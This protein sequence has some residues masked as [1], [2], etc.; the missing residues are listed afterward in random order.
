MMSRR[1]KAVG[2][3]G[4]TTLVLAGCAGGSG[5]DGAD[6]VVTIDFLA[7]EYSEAT[8]PYWQDLIERFEAEN[9]GIKIALQTISWSDINTKI[10]TLVSTGEEPDIINLDSYAAFAADELLLPA[11]EVLPEQSYDD[12]IPALLENATFDGTVYG[13]PFVASARAL[14][15]NPDILAEA[16]V[17]EAPTTWAQLKEAALAVT[18]KTD[19]IGYGMPVGAPEAFGEFSI[20]AWN[21]GG[22]WKDG[23]NWA[24]NQPA[25]VEALE[26]MAAMYNAGVTQES[27]WVSNR[28]DLFKM[29]GEGQI[30]IIEGAAFLPAVMEGQG[31]TIPYEVVPSPTNGKAAQATLAVQDYLMVFNSTE[32][33]EE[34]G[35]FLSFFYESENYQA[36]LKA[37]G[38][39]PVTQSAA[40]DMADDPIAGPFVALLENARFYPTT[41]PNW[42]SVNQEAVAKLGLAISGE[43][44]AQ[45]VLD[46]LQQYA[47]GLR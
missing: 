25:N 10:N 6:G 5:T 3:L 1:M 45:Q 15:Y 8:A 44:S 37:E 18:E 16:G 40:D 26:A 46:A 14:F 29:F 23:E 20:W 9:E 42:P 30:G 19:S 43:Q 7:P 11:D 34:A 22:G 17:A 31:S 36:F 12:L 47:E 28:D 27:P 39:L 32:H 13:I 35:A 33:P 38:M 4:A 24:I 41:D 21:N 2:V